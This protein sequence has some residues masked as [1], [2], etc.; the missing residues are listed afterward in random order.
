MRASPGGGDGPYVGHDGANVWKGT[1][2][3]DRRHEPGWEELSGTSAV[4]SGAVGSGEPQ[5]GFQQGEQLEHIY[6][7][8]TAS[9]GRV[10]S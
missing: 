5:K 2:K 7:R 1:A 9:G 8:M 10:D 3:G 6:V 4:G